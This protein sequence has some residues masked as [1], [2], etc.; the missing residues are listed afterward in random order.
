M[1]HPL[2]IQ[3]CL[4][5]ARMAEGAVA[6]NPMVGA[7]IVH[8][9]RI[10]GEGWHR[11]YGGPH[12]E[13]EAINAVQDKALLCEATLYVSLEPCSHHG[14][15][16]PCADLILHHRIPRVVVGCNDPNPL[17]AGQGIAKL[18]AAGVEVLEDVLRDEAIDLNRRFITFHS[19][20]R[21]YVS[22]KWAQTADGFVDAERG[23]GSTPLKI[24]GPATDV[25]MHRTRSHEMAIM[26]GSGTALA[27]DPALTVRHVQGRQP[28]RV[29]IDGQLRVPPSARLL[30]D[31]IATLI[32]N[33]RK[34]ETEG[35]VSYTKVRSIDPE[36]ILNVLFG[37]GIQSVL[38]EGGP[39]LQCA[40][41]ASGLW[42]EAIRIT[43]PT[44]IGKGVAA[45]LVRA[46]ERECIEVGGDTIR[47]L[48]RS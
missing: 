35:A 8:N 5:L 28:L 11:A 36:E 40:F 9:G 20:S 31:G 48:F 38:I 30:S 26:V 42:D 23:P 33:L 19:L 46:M 25:L 37:R 32:I 17:V 4:Q 7:V 12:A 27:D 29:L 39:T 6:P 22:L 34:D 41:I 44:A 18:R 16:P 14:K 24:T 47:Y 43:S 3:R 21:P 2:Y 15:T 1:E 10:I 45:P 13:V